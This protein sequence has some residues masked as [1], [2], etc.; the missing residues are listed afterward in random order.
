MIKKILFF[1]LGLSLFAS[2]IFAQDSGI[3]AELVY[4]IQIPKYYQGDLSGIMGLGIQFQF[5][6]NDVF[7]YGI[8]YKFEMIQGVYQVNENTNPTNKT[9]VFNNLGL[10]GKTS[11]SPGFL[12][13]TGIG[14]N[15][16]N[17]GASGD[18]RKYF[19]YYISGGMDV[20]ITDQWYLLANYQWS[21]AKKNTNLS[22]FSYQEK[23]STIRIGVGF[24]I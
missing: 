15:A 10:Y 4:P 9:Y 21:N 17:W 11:L 24:N 8:E 7:N 22:D 20:M 23:L 6:D 2:Q 14:G 19:G 1:S 18:S 3:S 13:Y 16:F 5:T 12:L